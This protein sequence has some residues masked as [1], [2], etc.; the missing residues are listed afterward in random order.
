MGRLD[1]P[2]YVQTVSARGNR[3]QYVARTTMRRYFPGEHMLIS[4]IVANRGQGG[5]IDVQRH[6]SK[7]P[8]FQEESACKFRGDVLRIGGRSAISGYEQLPARHHRRIDHVDGPR[9]GFG[10]LRK[11]LRYL[12]MFVPDRLDPV[13]LCG[14]CGHLTSFTIPPVEIV[15]SEAAPTMRPKSP[16][17]ELPCPTIAARKPSRAEGPIEP[18]S[19]VSSRT[20]V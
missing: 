4:V 20:P 8:A 14:R 12:Q 10:Q 18:V 2:Q 1:C 11:R 3:Q 13:Y 9:N 5:S 7:W 17:G 19:R 15:T 16:S 6:R